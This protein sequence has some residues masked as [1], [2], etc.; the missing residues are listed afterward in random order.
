MAI[1]IEDREELEA[2]EASA[3]EPWVRGS[4][5][6]VSWPALIIGA[7]SALCAMTV[8]GLIGGA[9]G[10]H[11][12]GADGGPVDWKTLGVGALAFAV[13]TAFFSYAIGGWV[14]GKL[15][16]GGRRRAAAHG[17]MAWV[18]S[19]PVMLALL[20]VGAGTSLGAL[21]A[22]LAPAQD[23]PVV[24]EAANDAAAT[25][26]QG[27]NAAANPL[28]A[29][30]TPAPDPAAAAA[31][32]NAALTALTLLLLGLAGSWLAGGAAGVRGE[33]ALENGQEVA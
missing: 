15:S 22:G 20:S 31:A 3:G 30:E 33:A 8:F 12:L 6:P 19:V 2:L 32:R 1:H 16:A 26:R 23:A 5:Y 17:A 11:Q 7:L 10:A 4:D 27:I 25:A 18:V 21:T 28:E 29:P 9:F 13:F 14:A 24:Q